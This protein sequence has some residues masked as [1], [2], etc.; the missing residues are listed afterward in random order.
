MESGTRR[1]FLTAAAACFAGASAPLPAWAQARRRTV[2][3][4]LK[5]LDSQFFQRMLA[6]AQD[7]Q[8]HAAD[9][10]NL[11]TASV[12]DVLD[13]AGQTRIVDRMVAD[14]VGAI[15]ISPAHSDD[16]IP[17]L[18]RAVAAGVIVINIDNRL[19]PAQLKRAGLMV[20]YVGPDNLKGAAKV[21]AYLAQRLEPGDP[22]AVIEGAAINDNARQR[23]A[24]Y[25][26]AMKTARARVVA[27][28][29]GSWTVNGG[30]LA[31]AALLAQYPNLQALLCGNDYMA[32]GAVSA[33]RA[34]GRRGK[35][36]V[37]GYDNIDAVRPLLKQG[38]ILAT[39]D[40]YAAKQAVFGIDTALKAIEEYR[41]QADLSPDVETPVDLVTRA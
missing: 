5:A 7:Y 15:V 20:P 1:R 17:A 25:L 2:G 3:L 6:G 18:R 22:V 23:T 4:V 31:A 30:R 29:S 34:A 12:G 35:V 37:V 13:S 8:A 26:D 9:R 19:D 40:Q 32:M 33:L 36:Y 21:G 10:F 16:I 39:A 11:V 24:G 28:R 38:L 14:K 27:I 41:S